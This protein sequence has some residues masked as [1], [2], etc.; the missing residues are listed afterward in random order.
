MTKLSEQMEVWKSISRNLSPFWRN[1]KRWSRSTP[2][3][4]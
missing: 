2:D 4:L 1:K 3:I